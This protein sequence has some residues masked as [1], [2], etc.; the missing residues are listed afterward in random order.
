MTAGPKNAAVEP[1]CRVLYVTERG[2]PSR[3]KGLFLRTS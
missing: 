2:P 1:L 3:D